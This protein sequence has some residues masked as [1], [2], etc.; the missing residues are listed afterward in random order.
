[1]QAAI[2]ANMDMER[3]QESIERLQEDAEELAEMRD[4]MLSDLD[5]D[6]A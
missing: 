5:F 1:M 6:S 2:E 3:Y 4:E